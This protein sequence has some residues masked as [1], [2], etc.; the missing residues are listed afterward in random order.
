MQ[1][2]MGQMPYAQTAGSVGGAAG[3]SRPGRPW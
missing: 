1:Q 2:Q 3:T